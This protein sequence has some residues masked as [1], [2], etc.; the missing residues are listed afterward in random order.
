MSRAALCAFLL[1]AACSSKKAKESPAPEPGGSAV[2]AGSGS[3]AGSSAGSGGSGGSAGSAAPVSAPEL[4]WTSPGGEPLLGLATSGAL[5]GPCG[6]IGGVTANDVVIDGQKFTWTGVERKGRAYQIAPLPWTI[7][8]SDAGAISLVNPG[9][10]TVALGTVTGTST[11]EGLRWFAALV[12]AA[13]ALQ[14][15]LG[16]AS[17]DGKVTYALSASADMDA[18]TIKQGPAVV[19]KK[20]RDQPHGVITNDAAEGV[21][22]S[23][24]TVT[25]AGPGSYDVRVQSPAYGAAAYTVIEADGGAL[26]W[27]TGDKAP[28]PLGTLSGRAACKAHD[29]A[30]AALIET[31]LSTKSGYAA[32]RDADQ[33]W[34]GK[35]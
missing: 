14:I 34:S 26:T 16:F 35:K 27:K 7:E 13:P 29:K 18:W 10:P 25:V 12:I 11:E 32:T 28:A 4:H 5:E 23:A 19:A 2:A 15:R 30:T 33:K 6:P 24:V 20:L 17:A 21:A 3:S 22:P 31:L 8:V 1:A 9:K